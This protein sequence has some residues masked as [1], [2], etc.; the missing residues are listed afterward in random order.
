MTTGSTGLAKADLL[1]G[2]RLDPFP[3]EQVQCQIILSSGR[4]VRE[5]GLD[6]PPQ[7]YQRCDIDDGQTI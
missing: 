4:Q 3:A 7:S 2:F 6:F 5:A 1:M